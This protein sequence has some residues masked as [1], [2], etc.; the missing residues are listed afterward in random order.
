MSPV[1]AGQS[2]GSPARQV[3]GFNVSSY[4]VVNHITASNSQQL[5]VDLAAA[6]KEIV[7]TVVVT[8]DIAHFR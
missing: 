7:C 8:V 4:A 1:F 5:V 3:V 6:V 2:C